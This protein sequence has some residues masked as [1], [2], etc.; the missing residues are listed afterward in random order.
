MK[1]KDIHEWL[2]DNRI[3][4]LLTI[5]DTKGAEIYLTDLLAKHLTEQLR[6]HAVMQAEGSDVCGAAVG[7]SA[8]G[9]GVRGGTYDIYKKGDEFYGG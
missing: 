5:K 2:L 7:N 9:K 3:D 6:Q 4:S 1:N 8:A